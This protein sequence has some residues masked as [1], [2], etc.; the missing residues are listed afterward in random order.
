MFDLQ[1]L[2]Q[3]ALQQLVESH[4]AA[5]QMEGMV[6]DKATLELYFKETQFKRLD[7]YRATLESFSD[8]DDD[9]SISLLDLVAWAQEYKKH[10]PMCYSAVVNRLMHQTE[11]KF[12]IVMDEFNCLFDKGHYFHMA[13]DEDVREAIPYDRINLFE[14]IMAA[15]DLTTMTVEEEEDAESDRATAATFEAAHTA[16]VVGTSEAHAVSCGVTDQ[17]TSCALRRDSVELVEVPRFSSLEADHVLANFEATGVGKLRLDRGDTL[18][19]PQE[20]E[21]LK[22]AS[23]SIGQ[24]LL[25]V[26]IF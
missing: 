12:M 13:Y 14:P 10:A 25:D 4:D 7:D 15:M 26:S 8:K 17:L 23:G 20:V 11:V 22:M 5:K 6:A 21:Y 24:K 2:S 3:E 1:D 9:G 19:N 16:V 18:M